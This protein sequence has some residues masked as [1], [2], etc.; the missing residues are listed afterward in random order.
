MYA[1]SM[2][3]K[4]IAALAVIVITL[5][6]GNAKAGGPTFGP[7]NPECAKAIARAIRNSNLSPAEFRCAGPDHEGGEFVVYMNSPGNRMTAGHDPFLEGQGYASIDYNT[8]FLYNDK[9]ATCKEAIDA[10]MVGMDD[11]DTSHYACYIDVDHN[12]E[13]VAFHD[14]VGNRA[15]IGAWTRNGDSLVPPK[16]AAQLYEAI[17]AANPFVVRVT[18][19]VRETCKPV[20]TIGSEAVLYD[21]KP[22][23][24]ALLDP[25]LL[26]LIQNYFD[27]SC[28]I[29]NLTDRPV[30]ALDCMG[31]GTQGVRDFISMPADWE[32]SPDQTA[33][34]IAA[35]L[36]AACGKPAPNMVGVDMKVAAYK[37]SDKCHQAARKNAIKLLAIKLDYVEDP[38]SHEIQVRKPELHGH[39]PQVFFQETIANNK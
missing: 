4:W 23:C 2:K 15:N 19:A 31:K 25:N 22:D 11:T 9:N 24:L 33:N 38:E 34:E 39:V 20:D 26:I 6:G 29:M 36:N 18:Q 27:R 14:E 32:L 30:I 21:A 7:D 3:S 12:G 35:E 8:T 16:I 17:R 37:G 5:I 13:F 10:Y 1:K 28:T